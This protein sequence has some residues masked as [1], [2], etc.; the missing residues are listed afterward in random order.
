[1]PLY[2]FYTMVQKSRKWPK[3]QIK[4]GPALSLALFVENE[5]SNECS[6]PHIS[7]F[8]SQKLPMNIRKKFGFQQAMSIESGIKQKIRR[9]QCEK[10]AKRGKETTAVA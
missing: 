1:M 2:L 4:G 6:K 8:L 3:T 10:F 5:H 7:L 9:F